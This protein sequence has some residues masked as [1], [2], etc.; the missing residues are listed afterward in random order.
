MY[1]LVIVVRR[2]LWKKAKE[3]FQEF[4][5]S[6]VFH[7]DLPVITEGANRLIS[8]GPKRA[9]SSY[10][11]RSASDITITTFQQITPM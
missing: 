9:L 4:G 3:K 7:L 1:V 6:Q 2:A 8:T 10:C 5:I 11:L